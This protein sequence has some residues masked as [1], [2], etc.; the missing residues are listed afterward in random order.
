MNKLL[1][2]VLFLNI[3]LSVFGQNYF[4]KVF[5]DSMIQEKGILV[6]QT[7]NGTIYF[8]GNTAQS[9]NI[10]A[11]GFYKM[12][13][14]GQIVSQ[15]NI[16]STNGNL[17]ANAMLVEDDKFVIVGEKHDNGN[18]DGFAL[19]IDTTGQVLQLQF[20]GTP[21]KTENFKSIIKN[22]IGEYIIS[23]FTTGLNNIGNDIYLTALTANLTQTWSTIEG[24]SRNEV[25]QKAIQLPNGNIFV[26]G[27]QA[28]I[29]GNY[30][31]YC[32]LYTGDGR[33]ISDFIIPDIYNGGS[34]S[35]ILDANN[36][37]VIIGEMSAP[38][39]ANFDMYLVKLNQNGQL[40][41]K[42]YL[43]NTMNGDA[44]FGII[45]PTNE[46]YLI[47]GY[48]AGIV[49][50]T[51]DIALFSTDTSGNVLESK[52][53]GGAG[54]EIG[55]TVAPSVNGRFLV[56]GFDNIGNDVQYMLIYDNINLSVSTSTVFQEEKNLMIFPNPVI[57]QRF[58]FNELI[59]KA[60]IQI[61]NPNG[62]LLEKGLIVNSDIYQLKNK[63]P[64]GNYFVNLQF[65]DF[66]KTIQIIIE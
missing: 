6:H 26:V 9:N 20:Y 61:F 4:Q 59:D 53:Y 30:N 23:G 60:R 15:Q 44:G 46:T 36:D 24:S 22:Q 8:I 65:E 48:A 41:W 12:T 54:I 63:L 14:T 19:A 28:Q 32:Q 45:Q 39:S 55:Y 13:A 7:N 47:T 51:Q 64:S 34:K 40:I 29:A 49:S 42:K 1:I 5:G 21:N 11:I 43:T 58:N 56:A 35:M 3:P 66:Q 16:T 33:F 38:N 10:A 18:I 2:V 17:F 50:Q 37:I 31:I 57:Q 62:E 52:F 25:G 27:D